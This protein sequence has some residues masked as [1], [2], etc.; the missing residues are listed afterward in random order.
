MW[1]GEARQRPARNQ[2]RFRRQV[3]HYAATIAII[4]EA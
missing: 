1:A 2:S 4:V 3:G